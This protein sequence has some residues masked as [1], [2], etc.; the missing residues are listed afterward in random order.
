M[1]ERIREL[2]RQA[3]DAVWDLDKDPTGPGTHFRP[4]GFE[5]K[6][7]ELIVQECIAQCEQVATAADAKSKSKFVTDDGRMLHEGMW[8]GAK[9]CSGQIKQ[10]FGVDR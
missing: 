9:N 10:H 6:F 5:Q 3:F 1:N 7:A 2:E 4:D 8:G